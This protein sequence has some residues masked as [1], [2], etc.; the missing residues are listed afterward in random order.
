MNFKT[1][2]IALGLFWIGMQSAHSHHESYHD[3][4]H[5]HDDHWHDH[6]WHDHHWHNRVYITDPWYHH[7]HVYF[8]NGN[9]YANIYGGYPY[10]YYDPSYYYF[11]DGGASLNVN[12]S[13]GP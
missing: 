3:H 9:S 10:Y 2:Y 6:H 4:G 5:W 12:I 13:L 11:P 8:Y 7:D 1:L